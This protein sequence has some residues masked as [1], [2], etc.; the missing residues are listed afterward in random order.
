METE[1]ETME[2][3]DQWLLGWGGG[4]NRG[5]QR[6]HRAVNLPYRTPE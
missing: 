1:D 4:M 6:L 5:A 2:Q 3:K